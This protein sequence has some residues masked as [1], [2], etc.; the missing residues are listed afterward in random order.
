MRIG[1]GQPGIDELVT[2]TRELGT[3]RAEL[4]DTVHDGMQELRQDNGELRRQI[5][6]TLGNGLAELRTELRELHQAL[7]AAHRDVS[8]GRREIDTLRR[9]LE[10][11]RREAAEARTVP[12]ET[13]RSAPLGHHTHP[14]VEPS[15]RDTAHEPPSAPPHDAVPEPKA[16]TLRAEAADPPHSTHRER[17]EQVAGISAADLVCHRDTWSFIVE[18]ATRNAHFQVPG[19]IQAGSAGEARVTVS[20]RTLIAILTALHDVSKNDH[21]ADIGDWAMAT[22]IYRRIADAVDTVSVVDPSPDT[23]SEGPNEEGRNDTRTRTRIVIDD[24]PTPRA[25]TES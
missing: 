12:A 8:E 15:P 11:I 3:L 25:A 6:D 23:S 19:E 5:T 13:P 7:A 18:Q 9:D 24:R 4:S 10:T 14:D 1:R 22:R 21:R 16:G 17:L 20:G 2:L